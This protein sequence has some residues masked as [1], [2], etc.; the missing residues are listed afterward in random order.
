[1]EQISFLAGS[2]KKFFDF[3]AK[4]TDKDKIALIS[5]NDADGICSAAIVSKVVGNIEYLSF[6]GYKPEILKLIVPELKTRKINKV[7]FTDLS[8]GERESVNLN[9]ITK[10]ADILIIDHHLFSSDL[11]SDKLTLIKARDDFPAS[12]MC[13]YL[14]SKIQKIDGW[15][16][17]I[18]TAADRV[19][20]YHNSNTSKVFED[21]GLGEAPKTGYFWKYVMNM[22]YAL[23]YF[24][25][26]E[27]EVYKALMKAKSLE[28]LDVLDEYAS[29]VQKEL[30]SHLKEFENKHEEVGDL[31]F[32]YYEPKYSINSMLV[33]AISARNKDMTYLFVAN[34]GK[35]LRISARRQD[36]R[37]D[38]VALLRS[39]IEGLPN[40]E[41]GGHF[42]A[43]GARVPVEFLDKFKENLFRIY[44]NAGI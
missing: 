18:G 21:F 1:M 4:L 15:I 8:I 26:K 29:D 12:Y 44:G 40:S 31:H 38:C 28:G 34:E 11:N 3:M 7:I 24:K 14:F 20:L 23:I 43:A 17:A 41:A 36:R 19:D 33:N 42:M 10:F 16:A 5:H 22:G 32:Y 39:A 35:F 30:D 37:I 13:Y 25:D 6:I 27:E 2:E 9:E